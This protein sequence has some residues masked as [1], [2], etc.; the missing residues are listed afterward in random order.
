MK[1]IRIIFVSLII[2]SMKSFAQDFVFFNDSPAASYYDPSWGFSSNG[3]LLELINTNKF[4][5]E[6]TIKYSGTNSLRLKY[7]SLSGGDWGIA[8]AGIDWPGRDVTTKDSLV[9]MAY[10]TTSI[11]ISDLP[12]VYLE[13]LTGAKTSKQPLSNYVST[14]PMNAWFK[15][16]VP[17][18]VF[19]TNPGSAD[20]TMIKTIFFGQNTAD[21]VQHLFYLDEIRMSSAA[22]LT[23]PG[24]PQNVSAKG[25]YRH[26]DISWDLNSETSV[27]GYRI[28]KF[29][30]GNY[31]QIG[32]AA[33]EDRFFTDFVGAQDLSGTYKVSAIDGSFNESELSAEVTA[34]T[35]IMN[36][37]ELLTMLQEA[38]FRYFWD[39]AHP[40][41]G[42]IRERY[43]SGNT[44]TIGGSGFGVMA[45]LVGIERGFI[46]RQQGTERI[47]KIAN[48]LETKAD[49]FHGIWSHWLNGQT[50]KVIPFGALDDGGDL[51]ES[52]FMLQG[53]LTARKYFDQNVAGEDS[54]RA[55]TTRLWES[56]EFDWY[57]RTASSNFLYWHWSPNYAWQINMQIAG[58]SEAMIVYILGI[59]SPTHGVPASLFKNGWAGNSY[60]KNGKIF[61]GYKLDVGWDYGG[62]LFFAHYSFLGFDPRNKK[63]SFT[64][65]FVN[66]KNHSLIQ[67][68]YAKL[69]P[70]GMPGY[71]ILTWGMTAS[72][73]PF[74]YGVH[75]VSR[76][77]GTISPTAALSSMPYT[78]TE[79]I[80]TLKNFYFTYGARIWGI[81]GFKDAFNVKENWYA[82]SYIAIDQGPII[83]M[84]ENYRSQLLWN[85]FM[86]N[87]E[88]D[89]A[90]NK[91]G[92]V[93]DP[94]DVQTKN[95]I[96]TEFALE[97]NYPNPFNP[98]TIISYKLAA[99][100]FV[101][102]KIF[103]VLG[104]QIAELVNE[105][106][107]AGKYHTNFQSTD[108]NLSSG[109]YFYQ[110][111]TEQ[112]IET[113]KMLILK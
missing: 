85:N 48:F 105:M 87:A 22:S 59:A 32:T 10:T 17:L 44:V 73:D 37:N 16:A 33:R 1:Y 42:L 53:L 94:T 38:T 76:D 3:S 109:I 30:N 81:Y 50:G 63:D 26:I 24:K 72:D 64:N 58:W 70:K 66:N 75:E 91:I 77:N 62:P 9:F 98:E 61:Y 40:G 39:Y 83:G 92:F 68:E 5:V 41:S 35:R 7:T 31:N 103:D 84:V 110:L 71:N 8:V 67:R 60:Y 52:S 112:F 104:N 4:P 36:D 34:T 74:G 12:I 54:I 101:T 80:M 90:M 56:A 6:T 93:P 88:I 19:K 65:Y 15:I 78:P 13:D 21:A 11:A 14:L 111:K 43:G 107:S 100:S 96:P 45:V 20:L 86:K 2:L 55:V 99:N 23:P 113:K 18:S 95:G 106:Q 27:T 89:S 57:R 82:S 97:Q 49:R 28:Y 47:L 29:V 102:L 51:V 79:S 25:Y 108:Y 46:S 69:N